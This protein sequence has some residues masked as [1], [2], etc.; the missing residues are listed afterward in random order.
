MFSYILNINTNYLFSQRLRAY[1][2]KPNFYE[3][4]VT[5]AFCSHCFF[6]LLQELCQCC[7]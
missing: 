4:F 1:N 5:V 6:F 2:K 7:A 3:T